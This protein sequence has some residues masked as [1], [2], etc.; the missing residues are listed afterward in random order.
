MRERRHAYIDRVESL[1]GKHILMRIVG[2]AS[3]RGGESVGA[4]KIRIGKRCDMDILHA[5]QHSDVAFG[6]PARAHEADFHPAV[7]RHVMQ[8]FPEMTSR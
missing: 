3:N 1:D 4:R 7:I 5:A 6:N 8:A 2:F